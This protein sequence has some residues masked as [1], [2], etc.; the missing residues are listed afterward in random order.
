MK[1]ILKL[2]TLS[3]VG[4]LA[5]T[6]CSKEDK[7]TETSSYL[8]KYEF[9]Y[10]SVEEEGSKTIMYTC[11]TVSTLAVGGGNTSSGSVNIEESPAI[12]SLSPV[13]NAAKGGS[14]E[15]KEDKIIATS[16]STTETWYYKVNEKN[17]VLLAANNS[18][19][20]ATSLNDA[21][22]YLVRVKLENNRIYNVLGNRDGVT[23]VAVY[24]M[25]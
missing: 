3:L 12:S 8:G 9:E 6:G 1:G 11:P 23:I 17:E 19:K 7:N 5:F 13:C 2:A 21:A 16:D 18:G 14:F 4:M 20:P 10:L 24:K 22:Y 15:I 25:K